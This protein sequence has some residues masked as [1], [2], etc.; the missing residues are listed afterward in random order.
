MASRQK[1]FT[2]I[3]V[4]IVVAVVGILAA[5][6]YPSY[7]GHMQRTRRAAA[8][9]CM[10][11]MAEFLERH[12]TTSGSYAGAKLTT[13]LNCEN[14]LGAHYTLAFTVDA[15]KPTEFAVTAVPKGAQEK[16]KC[17]TLGLNHLGKKTAK[18]DGC[19]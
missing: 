12:Y 10:F 8:T 15:A 13:P 6:A 11:E 2:L 4:M 18:V 1:G 16:D 7:Q 14:E 9:G 5:I 17:E 19:F 3:E